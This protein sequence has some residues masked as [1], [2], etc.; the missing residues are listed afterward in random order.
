MRAYIRYIFFFLFLLVCGYSRAQLQII[1]V[2]VDS[3]TN[4]PIEKV[5][6]NFLN[7]KKYKLTD[8]K[9]QFTIS[10]SSPRTA[11]QVKCVGYAPQR[12]E[13]SQKSDV[14][15]LDTI[16][17]VPSEIQLEEV[18]VKRKKEKYSKKNNPAVDF[19]N[20]LR[21]LSDTY[22]PLNQ[23]YYSY[24]KYN[25]LVLGYYVENSQKLDSTLR[26]YMDYSVVSGREYL[27]LS[28]KEKKSKVINRRRPESHKEIVD[29]YRSYG[30]DESFDTQ[31]MKKVLEDV[32][33]EIDIYANDITL[34]QNR[35]V[36]PLS[37]IG[38]DFYKYYLT[39]TVMISNEPCIELVFGPHNRETFGFSG[40]IYVPLNDTT[41]FVR[42]VVMQ[43][44]KSINLNYVNALYIVQNFERDSLGNRH[45]TYDRVSVDF[46]IVSGKSLLH[47]M[48]E[49]SCGGFSYTEES[50]YSRY[51]DVD[52]KEIFLPESMRRDD[53][54]WDAARDVRLSDSQSRMSSLMADLRRKRWFYWGEKIVALMERGYVRTSK[55]SKFD[56]GPLNT[57]FSANKLEGA[58]F[59][60]GGMTTGTL[61]NHW[62][63]RF[64]TA[65][66]TKD[67]KWMYGAE[68]EYSFLAK[69][70]HSREY[71][72]NLIR[73]SYNYDIDQIGQHYLFTNADNIFLSLKRRTDDKITYRRLAKVEYILEKKSGFALNAVLKYERQYSTIYMPFNFSNGASLSNYK[74][75]TVA[76]EL[77]YAPGEEFYQMASMRIPINFD[78]PVIML[79]H[80]FGPSGLF[81]NNFCF[82]KTELSLEKRFWFSAFGYTDVI[83][84]GAKVWGKAYFPDLTW[85]NANL[86]YTIQPESFALLNPMEF[87]TDQYM[88]WD[89]TYWGNGVLFNRIPMLKKTKLREVVS[90]RGYYGSLTDKNNPALNADL[91]QFPETA[92]VGLM[93]KDPYMEFGVGLDNIFTFLRLDYVWRLTYRGVPG[94]DKSGLRVALHFTF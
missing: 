65:Y 87:A 33:R 69:K 48:R 45:K 35:F 62:F 28:I 84:K 32:F 8:S 71:P 16:R 53:A 68:L 19:V 37:K 80:E 91:I 26:R 27:T 46:G 70:K 5:T 75:T 7:E 93:K 10:S 49:T 24:D 4:T 61:S 56:I 90:F 41:M 29:G 6:V 34:M 20:R 92:C 21:T 13:L 23:D 57:L 44:P 94:T 39:D 67:K 78:S 17:L 22:N 31:N 77:K 54:Y 47:A 74:K 3:A 58:R 2:V 1:G 64:Y 36:S 59:R 18:V 11:I 66:G 42:K 85:A 63:S 15:W 51:Y 76:L 82:N 9:G 86:S 38:P 50:A 12:V 30:V 60:L 25:K 88:S 83:L 89:L 43:T 81:G 40:R 73:V 52:G 55:E 79:T 14:Q 72:M